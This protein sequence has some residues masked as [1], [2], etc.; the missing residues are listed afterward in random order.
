MAKR[1]RFGSR[2]LPLYALGGYVVS[3]GLLFGG[4]AQGIGTPLRVPL[5]VMA[6]IAFLAGAVVHTFDKIDQHNTAMLGKIDESVGGVWDAG[7]RAG[8]RHAA[9]ADAA[10]TLAVVHDLSPR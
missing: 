8:K 10:P 7:E 9:L 4:A 3:G 5:M 6:I 1:I 2:E